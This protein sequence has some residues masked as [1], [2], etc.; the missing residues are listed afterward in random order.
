MAFLMRDGSGK[1]SLLY[2]RCADEMYCKAELLLLLEQ[3]P[4]GKVLGEY[5]VD[6]S[7]TVPRFLQSYTGDRL[8]QFQQALERVKRGE[9]QFPETGVMHL[10]PGV[11]QPR[12]TPK[13]VEQRVETLKTTVEHY[14]PDFVKAVE[15]VKHSEGEDKGILVIHQDAFAASYHKDEYT[16][17]GLAIKYAGLH[18]VTVTITS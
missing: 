5:D 3:A 8:V 17:L 11:E 12:S 9:F 13:Q 7:Y 4:P 2:S 14:L 6:G 15:A 1:A 18:G 10:V 16:L